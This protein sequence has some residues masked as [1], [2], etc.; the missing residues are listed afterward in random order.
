VIDDDSIANS[1]A[2]AA[3]AGLYD[4]TA[5]LMTGNNPLISFRTFAEV[6]VID[7]SDIRAADCGCLYPEQDLA[8]A[9][10]RYRHGTEFN[11]AVARQ[12]RS[13]HALFNVLHRQ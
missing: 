10:T 6:F 9:G 11:S 1:E 2:P 8:M 3:G 4:L 13:T 12:I 5:W 7:T